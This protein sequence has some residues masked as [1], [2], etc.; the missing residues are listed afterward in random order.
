MSRYRLFLP[1][2]AITVSAAAC[3]RDSDSQ[4][5]RRS[6][7][8]GPLISSRTTM[9]TAWE[10]PKNPLTDPTLDD[11]KLS[12]D[13]KWGFRIF[14]NTPTEAPHLAPSRVSC[15]NCHLNAGQRERSLPLVSVAGMFPEYNRR[16]GRLYSLGDRIVDCFLRSENATGA[17]AR[18]NAE[19]I[20]ITGEADPETPENLV[21]RKVLPSTTSKEVLAV[22]AYLTW[23]ARG[24]EVGRNPPWRGQNT[25]APDKLIPV[26]ELDPR[27]GEAIF[28]ERCTSC[29]GV[30]G[31]GV[32]IGDKK[33]GPLW[34]PDSWNDGAGAARV[35]TLAGIV[36][37]AM[38]YLDPGSLTDEDAQHVA[39]FITSKPRPV[40]P[41]K[42]QDYLTEKLPADAVYYAKR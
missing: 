18:N 8:S 34:G 6:I 39:A 30:D 24:S 22:S 33:A 26:A 25:I 13:I 36:R 2:L 31:Q 35:Y 29:H 1:L 11:S 27:K 9:V 37:Y 17:L 20:V 5:W 16:S 3:R 41:F 32:A 19:H 28:M 4:A 40:Y 42:Q 14:T 38:P 15:S 12:T 21:E 10:I 23:L 7:L